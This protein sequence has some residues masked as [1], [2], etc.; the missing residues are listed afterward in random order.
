[1][2]MRYFYV[3]DQVKHKQYDVRFHP[4]QEKLGNYTIKHHLARHHMQVRPIY[5]HMKNSQRFLPMAMT[6]S[7]M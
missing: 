7:N 3:C 2:E 6:P 4:G 5:L 1:M